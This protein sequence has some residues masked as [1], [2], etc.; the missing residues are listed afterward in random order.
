MHEAGVVTY[1]EAGPSPDQPLPLVL[2]EGDG[3]ARVAEARAPGVTPW[4]QPGHRVR[5]RSRPRRCGSRRAAGSPARRPRRRGGRT[6]WPRRGPANPCP[7]AP[8]QRPGAVP[9]GRAPED[10]VGIPPLGL[11]AGDPE[12]LDGIRRVSR[13]PAVSQSSTGHPPNAV[14]SETTSRVTPGRAFTIDRS[15]PA[16][17]LNSRL[18]P[19]FGRPAITTFQPPISRTPTAARPMRES[20]AGSSG[21]VPLADFG[22]QPF[23]GLAQ[24]AVGLVQQDLRDPQGGGSRQVLPRLGVDASR[25]AP[26]ADPTRR[27]PGRRRRPPAIGRSQR[28]PRVPP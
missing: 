18:L 23:Q 10:E 2:P 16:R 12:P 5:R 26:E 6:C 21:G 3:G 4:L 25:V 1:A 22:D 9:T 27:H 19:T 8:G 24:G 14:R 20:R 15:K 7:A 17:A 13:S 28:W 11:R